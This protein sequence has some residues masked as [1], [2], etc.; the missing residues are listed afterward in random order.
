MKQ[1]FLR[2]GIAAVSAVA[3]AA[4]LAGCSDDSSDEATGGDEFAEV[5][6]FSNPDVSGATDQIVNKCNTDHSTEFRIKYEQLPS[7]SDGQRAQLTRRL[8]AKDPAIDIMA[9]DVNWTAEFAAAGW[10][11]EWT[12]DA[13]SKAEE[14]VLEGALETATYE[15]KLYGVPFNTNTQLLWYRKDLVPTPPKTWDEMIT[16][17]EGLAA[18]N[19]PHYIEVQGAKYEGLVVWFNSL[20]NS[21]GGSILNDDGDKAN[22]G[23]AT[24]KAATVMNKLAKSTAAD[25]SLANTQE[26]QARLAFQNGTA[27]FMLNWP[28]VYA[29]SQAADVKPEVKN[30]IGWAPWP[31]VNTGEASKPTVGGINLGLSSFSEKQSQAIK[32]IECLRSADNQKTL[33]SVA[34]LPPV[35]DSVYTDAAVTNVY[36]MAD[37]IKEGVANGSARPETPVYPA[38]ST[39]IQNALSPPANIN[40]NTVNETLKTGIDQALESKGLQ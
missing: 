20:V 11:K 25:P 35:L 19:K 12:G 36:P 21:A 31:S 22:T 7:D 9:M 13:K 26:D 28:Y 39:A 8:S 2:P 38:V 5:S 40:L 4:T 32:A 27:A 23:E 34:S 18:Q 3:L 30:N 1:R 10:A 15:D 37:L 16:M 29:A 24:L 14:G 6:F 33:A 17:A